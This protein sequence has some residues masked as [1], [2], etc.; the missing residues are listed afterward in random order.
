MFNW[1]GNDYREASIIDAPADEV[2][3]ALQDAKRASLGFLH[4]VQTEAPA[5]GTT[6]RRPELKLR[7]DIMG[8]SDGLAK[9]PYIRESRRIK[10]LRTVVEQDVSA[11]FQKG[12]RAASSRTP[13]ASAGIRSTSIAPAPRTSAS[14]VARARSRSRSAP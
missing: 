14:A 12:P 7:T 8:T 2:A 3:A 6:A 10:A 4:W 5:E 11:D 13:S 1:P 9:H